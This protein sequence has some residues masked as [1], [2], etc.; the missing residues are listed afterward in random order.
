MIYL[1]WLSS[2]T[3]P[4]NP[5]THARNE[6]KAFRGSIAE[7]EEGDIIVP[8]FTV[9]IKNPGIQGIAGQTLRYA[10]ISEKRHGQAAAEEIARGRLTGLPTELGDR[11]CTLEFMCVPPDQDAVLRAAADLLRRGEEDY[12]PE[13]EPEVREPLEQYDPLFFDSN[14]DEDPVTA[15]LARPQLWRWNRK[16]LV[17]E[18]VHLVNGETEHV[19]HHAFRNNWSFRVGVPPKPVSKLRVTCAYTQ[20]ARGV[21]NSNNIGN[22]ATMTWQDFMSKLPK[23]GDPIGSDS[24][25]F[26]D[27]FVAWSYPQEFPFR[28]QANSPEYGDAQGAWISVR[29]HDVYYDWTARYEYQQAREEILD[30]SMSADIQTVVGGD[31]IEVIETLN[32]GQLNIDLITDQWEFEDATTLERKHYNVGDRV[33]F[34]GRCW[35]CVEEHDATE[36]FTAVYGAQ[37]LWAPA[38]KYCAVRDMRTPRFF[39][40]D[41]GVR[42]VRY[43][44]RRLQRHV[45][46]ASRAAE[47]GFKVAWATALNITTKD[48]VRVEN[49]SM[50]GGEAVGKVT[51]VELVIDG[52]IRY[53]LITIAVPIGKGSAAPT[54]DEGEFLAGDVVYKPTYGRISIPVN[55]YTLAT[56]GAIIH[57]VLRPFG[58]QAN[59]ADL[60][61]FGGVDPV[62]AISST[63]T[64]L[65]IGFKPIQEEDLLRRRIAVHCKPIS[66]PKGIDISPTV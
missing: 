50:P 44:V 12:D 65:R 2:H 45:L 46:K 33:Q 35:S 11:K 17:P 26:F 37:T 55:A 14:A 38:P 31:K 15:I 8:Y 27:S 58:E 19:I 30:I 48:S 21:Q 6:F 40:I 66:V 7:R 10:V 1:A 47:I 22:F 43:A 56:E 5:V 4:F 29:P 51:S 39:D 18:L 20:E 42:A 63:P 9:E 54:P 34:D 60:A 49:K 16:T 61:S 62:R 59:N 52:H 41:R 32:L 24:G 23:A 13:A 64:Q 28:V 25:W 36:V 3:E 57:D 53:G